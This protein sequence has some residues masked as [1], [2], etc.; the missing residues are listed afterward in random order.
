MLSPPENIKKKES[1][2]KYQHG[3]IFIKF[4]AN[5]GKKLE[6]SGKTGETRI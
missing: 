6:S 1:V 5:E 3:M 4:F 2:D